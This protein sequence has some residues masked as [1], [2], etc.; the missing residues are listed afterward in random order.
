MKDDEQKQP[1]MDQTMP[2]QTAVENMPHRCCG[3]CAWR[4]EDKVELEDAE[5]LNGSEVRCGYNP[6]LL[7]R[8]R[9]SRCHHHAFT[10]G[11]DETDKAQLGYA[12]ETTYGTHPDPKEVS[13]PY[14][15]LRNDLANAQEE[16]VAV[17]DELA[18]TKRYLGA[19]RG[20]LS[21][22]K[23]ELA[24]SKQNLALLGAKLVQMKKDQADK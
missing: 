3:T 13:I 11:W 7:I 18:T 21:A 24:A 15:T 2:E 23:E 14:L 5:D 22:A 19:M 9:I 17:K 1:E 20:K 6:E 12:E 16:L 4:L 10:T 8:P